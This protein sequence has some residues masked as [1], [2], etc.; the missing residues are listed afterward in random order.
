[1]K[2]NFIINDNDTDSLTDANILDFLFK[3]IKG[4]VE[5]KKVNVNN[6]KCENASINVF[7]GIINNLLLD[8][9][10]YN[11]LIPNQHKF[12]KE[13]LKMLDNFDM[14][15]AK[16]KYIE[17]LFKSFVDK[18]KIK[19]VGWRSTDLY[20]NIDKDYDEIL[21]YCYDNNNYNEIIK[22]WEKDLPTLNVVNGQQYNL[23]KIKEQQD[24]I[25]F[26]S[27]KQN[28]FDNLFNRCGV[29]LCLNEIE[30]YSHTINQ[31][32]LV[33]SIPVVINNIPM[34]ENLTS[35]IAFLVNGVKKPL[36]SFMGS[37]YI[38]DTDDLKDKIRQ[39]QKTSITTLEIM[40]E[41]ARIN[42]IKY[43]GLNDLH[44]KNLF[45]EI[46][47][48]VRQMSA[49][50][51]KIYKKL[52]SST[53]QN[54]KPPTN[55]SNKS[56]NYKNSQIAKKSNESKIKW[57]IDLLPDNELPKISIVTLTHNREFMF[58]LA[59]YN[60]NT[61][62]YPRDKIEWV[63]YDTSNDDNKIEKLIPT[64]LE[65]DKLGIKYIY[66]NSIIS[67]GES[68]NN[69]IS[70]CSNDIVLFMDDDDYYPPDSI[71]TRVSILINSGKRI[72]GCTTIGSFDINKFISFIDV[73]PILNTYSNRISP[74]T[75][76][77][78][79]KLITEKCRFSHENIFECENIFKN[80]GSM[81]YMDFKEINWE[82]IIVS[83]CHNFNTTS[84]NVPDSK[85]NGCHYGWNERLFRFIAELESGNTE[86]TSKKKDDGVE[87]V[88]VAKTT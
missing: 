18:D 34:K 82:N 19:F 41:N 30:S 24:N 76:C 14:I 75:L 10:K 15:L 80:M 72:I 45:P 53:E 61:I 40:G 77:F 84:R 58:K 27:I 2:I 32:C 66:N 9:A 59:I 71:K 13:W 51:N 20:N 25:V 68:R 43:H 83:L 65:R 70:E 60:Y 16:T 47:L 49:S 63:I 79:K 52:D 73:P 81:G 36:K 54:I 38:L 26:H 5:I 23:H 57:E 55:K 29:H 62:N 85:P 42:A 8:Y 69:A 3:K 17:S 56:K 74:A 28:E 12:K 78:Y 86:D 64:E 87:G 31:C 39:M 88:G 67:I 35:D 21:L 46:M 4:K 50:K 11:I 7:F 1:M 44:F 6:Y 33:K 48:T 37:R 22:Q